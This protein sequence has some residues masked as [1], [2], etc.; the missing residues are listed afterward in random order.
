MGQIMRK[1]DG[2][3]KYRTK[4]N[5]GYALIV[6]RTWLCESYKMSVNASMSMNIEPQNKEPQNFEGVKLQ[7]YPQNTQ[8]ISPALPEK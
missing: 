7:R 1:H 3:P 6:G 8:F 2:I 4:V 5:P